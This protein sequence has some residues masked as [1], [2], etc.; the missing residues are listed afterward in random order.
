MDNVNRRSTESICQFTNFVVP[1]TVR[2]D[3]LAMRILVSWR[4]RIKKPERYAWENA[5]EAQAIFLYVRCS[6]K[7]KFLDIFLFC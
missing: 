5:N 2:G 6:L 1:L 7:I 4:T 3:N